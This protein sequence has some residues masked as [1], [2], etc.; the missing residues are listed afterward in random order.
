MGAAASVIPLPKD[1][2][3]TRTKAV[4][5]GKPT[6]EAVC[7]K[8]RDGSIRRVIVLCGAGISVNAGIPDFRTKGTGLYDNLEAYGLPTPESVFDLE[9]FKENPKPFCTLAKTLFPDVYTPKSKKADKTQTGRMALKYKPTRTHHF[10]NLLAKKGILRRVFTQNIDGLEYVA[11]IPPARIVQCHGGFRSSSCI[12]CG[13][14]CSSAWYRDEI[15]AG[16]IP[17]C[18]RVGGD[19]GEE[20]GGLCKA[21]ITFFGEGLP[22][23]FSDR[24]KQDMTNGDLL[25][26]FGTSLKVAPVG[27]LPSEVSPFCPRV[28]C[29]RDPAL[30]LTNDL[31]STLKDGE[32]RSGFGFRFQLEDNYRDVFVQGD[33]DAAVEKMSKEL[34]W[35]K[36]LEKLEKAYRPP[37]NTQSLYG[38]KQKTKQWDDKTYLPDPIPTLPLEKDGKKRIMRDMWLEGDIE[39]SLLAL[40]AELGWLKDLGKYSKQMATASQEKL[41]AALAQCSVR[42]QKSAKWG[43]KKKKRKSKRK[44]LQVKTIK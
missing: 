5:G 42:D 17:R 43:N 10:M 1:L 34:G 32:T 6:L 29:N 35:F 18:T 27:N 22:K 19:D 13:K 4:L 11:G 38:A 28:L 25:L 20:C 2:D 21:D 8:I 9:F 3:N 33:C 44:H 39:D 14:A 12:K 26:V 15:E 23:E 7:A 41:K 24:K 37:K 31:E 40:A 30:V 16:R 36:E